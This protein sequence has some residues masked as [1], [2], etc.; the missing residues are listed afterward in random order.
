MLKWFYSKLDF[1]LPESCGWEFNVKTT[2]MDKQI[3]TY[4]VC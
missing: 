3:G 4:D 1:C 2:V